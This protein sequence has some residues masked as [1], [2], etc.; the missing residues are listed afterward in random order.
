MDN[1]KEDKLIRELIESIK[2]GEAGIRDVDKLAGELGLDP[3]RATNIRRRIIEKLTGT[4]LDNIGHF[5]LD[6]ERAT[7]RN[8][9][10][11]IGVAQLP[12]G[13]A[14]PL[15]VNGEL[16][17]GE[18][19][20]PLATTEGALVASINRGCKAIS[21]SGGANVR[22]IDDKMTRAALFKV[23]SIEDA[24]GFRDWV[25]ENF[26]KIV[27][28][29]KETSRHLRIREIRPWIVGKN[30]FLRFEGETGDAM[31]MNMITI[32]VE[33]ACSWI[34]ENYPNAKFVSASGNMCIDKKSS[35][36]NSLTGRGKTVVADIV[37]PR[38]VVKSILKTEPEK[39]V[40]VAYRKNLV[41]SA[42]AGSYGFNAHFANVIAAVYIA[43]G[44]DAAHVV[45]GSQGFSLM[46]MQGDEL[47]ASVMIPALQVGTVG[48]GT[49]LGTQREA[50]EILGVAGGGNPPGTNAKKLA[51]IIGAAVLAGE[52]SLIGALAA[53]HLGK[54]HQELGRGK[55]TS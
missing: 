5:S 49:G 47:H 30:V 1:E 3:K 20:I 21:L 50:L 2:A 42:L 12:M 32:A 43:T 41:G 13:I 54:A 16:A 52:L 6:V 8:I 37:L 55:K 4:K 10:N 51:E 9:E 53:R 23:D 25:I 39:M 31:G 14:G 38:E 33:H 46:E 45:E 40:E 17:K 11:M 36:L 35:A 22:V 7:K 15:K 34:E 27:E 48:G 18:F 26:D 24:V 29:T 28:K 19:Y 44:Q